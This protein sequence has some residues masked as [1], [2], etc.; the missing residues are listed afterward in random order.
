MIFKFI[1]EVILLISGAFFIELPQSMP[2]VRLPK[3]FINDTEVLVEIVDTPEAIQKG[4]SGRPSLDADRGMLFMFSEA[5]IY[6]F[7][8]PD[9][10]FPIDIIWISGDRVADI[11]ENVSNEFDPQNPMFYFPSRPVQ[12]VLELNAGFARKHNIKI[13]DNVKL[14][15]Q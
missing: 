12:T 1:L 7:W 2:E 15:L 4:L 8:M 10:H 14:F 5:K 6:K 9:M 11:D 13:G 3:V